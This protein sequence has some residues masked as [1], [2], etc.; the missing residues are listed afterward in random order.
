MMP[1]DEMDRLGLPEDRREI[2]RK[3]NEELRKS[4]RRN[5]VLLVLAGMALSAGVFVGVRSNREC[6]E[7]CKPF[8]G[9]LRGG[10]WMKPD[11]YCDSRKKMPE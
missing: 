3:M 6:Y 5:I 4:R 1:E 10:S 7:M 9:E 8:V 2:F 11:C